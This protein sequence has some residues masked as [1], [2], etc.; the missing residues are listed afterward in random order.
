MLKKVCKACT[1][2][3]LVLDPP[4]IYIYYFYV[5]FDETLPH[6]PLHK[7]FNLLLFHANL[8]NMLTKT[9]LFPVKS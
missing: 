3:K 5:K 1:E 4:H 6:I 9:N 8:W 7:Q 2:K